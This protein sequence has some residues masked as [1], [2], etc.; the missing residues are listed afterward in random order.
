MPG[1]TKTNKSWAGARPLFRGCRA[2][3]LSSIP[4]AC[5][6]VGPSETDILD[7]IIRAPHIAALGLRRAASMIA[8]EQF[9]ELVGNIDDAPSIPRFGHA[10][11]SAL[12]ARLRG[13]RQ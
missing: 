7:D 10:R 13:A 11:R 5:I 2:P 8:F 6:V 3:P 9:S 12:F 1:P 4:D